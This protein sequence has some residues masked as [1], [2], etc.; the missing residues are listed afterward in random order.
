MLAP[1]L[2][3]IQKENPDKVRLVYRHFPLPMHNNALITTQ[4]AEAAGLQ[5]KFWEMHDVIYA[6]QA[7]WSQLSVTDAQDWLISRAGELGLDVGKFI[8]DLTSEVIVNKARQSQIDAQKAQINSTPTLLF[9]GKPFSGGKDIETLRL[10]MKLADFAQ[11]E[12]TQCPE[13]T[14]DP[15]KT[16]LA[17]L[18]TAKG[19]IVLELYPDIAPMAVNNFIFLAKE[20]WFDG[21]TFH[22]VLTD[23]VAQTGD[24]TGTG[25]GGP[26]YYFDNEISPELSFDQPGMVGMANSGP[27]TNGSQ[28]FI[29]FTAVPELTGNYTVFG[30]VVVGLETAQNLTPRDPSTDANLPEGDKIL[31]VTIQEK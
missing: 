26:G 28:F 27:G 25:F 18:T 19:D 8:T 5:G 15:S 29:T 20:G 4:A 6:K 11:R 13:M 21:V 1:V 16:Y 30:K 31:K 7:E 14:I 17:V 24:P 23:F 10:F 3:Q 9:N 22:R 2:G 12:F